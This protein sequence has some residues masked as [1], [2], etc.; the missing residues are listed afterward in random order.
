MFSIPFEY[1]RL[2]H[3]STELDDTKELSAYDLSHLSTVWLFMRLKGGM[4]LYVKTLTGK[5]ICIDVEPSN[6]ILEVKGKVLDKE[7]IPCDQ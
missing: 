3:Q 2:V 7:G 4:Q 6:T 5:T 1:Q